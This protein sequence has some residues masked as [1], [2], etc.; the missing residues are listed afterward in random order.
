MMTPAGMIGEKA[1]K[2]TPFL[3]HKRALECNDAASWLLTNVRLRHD[4]SGV[5]RRLNR[6]N[7]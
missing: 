1:P 2:L 7:E 3:R 4:N 6:R 5:Q